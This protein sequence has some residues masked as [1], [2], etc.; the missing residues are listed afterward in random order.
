MGDR[1]NNILTVCYNSF[2]VK[3][4]QKEFSMEVI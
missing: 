1:C 4:R 2:V 3:F